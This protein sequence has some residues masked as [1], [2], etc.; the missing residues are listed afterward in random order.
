MFFFWFVCFFY[1]KPK[2]E[3]SLPPGMY[4]SYCTVWEGHD[5]ARCRRFPGINPSSPFPSCNLLRMAPC[6]HAERHTAARTHTRSAAPERSGAPR[7]RG[8]WPR[9]SWRRGRLKSKSRFLLSLEPSVT[10]A[11]T[12][13]EHITHFY[14]HDLEIRA[15]SNQNYTATIELFNRIQLRVISCIV[16]ESGGREGR[17]GRRGAE[18]GHCRALIAVSQSRR[19]R[20][21]TIGCTCRKGFLSFQPQPNKPGTGPFVNTTTRARGRNG[22]VPAFGASVGGVPLCGSAGLGARR[23]ALCA[24]CRGRSAALSAGSAGGAGL[25]AGDS[26][27]CTRIPCL[28]APC[29]QQMRYGDERSPL[30][31]KKSKK[32]GKQRDPSMQKGKTRLTA[33]GCSMHRK[34]RYLPSGNSS[35]V[36][37][38]I[39]R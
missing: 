25:C 17:A 27:F 38:K 32:G 39:L 36:G 4:I 34:N 10:G 19:F 6:A 12:Q 21:P 11:M 14:S 15:V 1:R 33:A 30:A 20:V 23:G 8:D 24:R 3:A 9:C 2:S 35:G 5:L 16:P 22:P 18:G 29:M 7:R 31:L 26:P 37:K 28:R 13:P